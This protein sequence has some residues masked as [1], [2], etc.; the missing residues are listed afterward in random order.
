MAYALDQLPAERRR[1]A[2]SSI[3]DVRRVFT[4]RFGHAQESFAVVLREVLDDRRVDSQDPEE[5]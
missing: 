2:A 5:S 4:Q 3:I 1:V